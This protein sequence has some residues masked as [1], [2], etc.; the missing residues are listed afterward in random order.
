MGAPKDC[1]SRPSLTIPACRSRH[2]A[3]V[4][5]AER[6]RPMVYTSTLISAEMERTVHCANPVVVRAVPLSLA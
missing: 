4:L 1:T 6:D 2:V 3:L 5:H